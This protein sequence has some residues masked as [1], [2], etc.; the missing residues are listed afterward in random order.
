MSAHVIGR[1]KDD[2]LDIMIGHGADPEQ[3]IVRGSEHGR[4]EGDGSEDHLPGDEPAVL[5]L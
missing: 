3:A 2:L 5:E 1:P 4:E